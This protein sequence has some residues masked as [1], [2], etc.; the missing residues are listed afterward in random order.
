MN[1]QVLAL[2]VSGTPR[3][4][5]SAE[6]A[7]AYYARS[8]VAWEYGETAML[9]RG[10]W[11]RGGARSAIRVSS[12][13]AVRGREFRVV[14]GAREP[15]LTNEKLFERDRCVCAYCGGRFRAHQLSRE[16]VVPVS[17][18][19]SDSWRNLVTACRGCNVR[20][21]NRTPE[22]ARMPLLYLPYVP[23]RWEDFILA[24]RRIL[25]DQM[26]YLLAKVPA[27]SR[28]RS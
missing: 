3:K 17:R 14:G 22:E 10:G 2:D 9:F 16:H 25:A 5:V 7:V 11:Q 19:G 4:W 27:G 21:G 1:R 13:I 6:D 24:N 26:A 18:G 12:I 8:L 28:L 23:S 15:L 20:K